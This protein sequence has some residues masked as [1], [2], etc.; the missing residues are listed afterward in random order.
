M[1][2]LYLLMIVISII[3]CSPNEQ[4]KTQEPAET[5]IQ[6]T[7]NYGEILL[8]LYNETPL[9]RDNFTKIV[10]EGVLDSVL[11][12]R[13]IEEFM[14]QAGNPA[15]K[16]ENVDSLYLENYNYR[17]PAEITAE[18]FHKKGALA[19]ARTGNPERESSGTQFYI[20]QGKIF[21]DSLLNNAEERINTW[22]SE[23]YIKQD[24]IYKN[25]LD[26]LNIALEND[27]W[28]E[29]MRLNNFFVEKAKSY[30]N[31]EKYSIPEA[32]K[33]V[34]RSVGGT[35]HLDQNYTVFGEVISGLQVV[36]SIASV[37]TNDRD[38]PIENVRII[39]A[40]VIKEKE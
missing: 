19:A 31:F 2:H 17:V 12:H 32:H 3:G 37:V 36:D 33:T 26:S 24:S 4:D 8:K 15:T 38:R 30:D 20:V 6:L 18:L 16:S 27:N 29:F 14:I 25:Q 34:Y 11:F 9:H 39:K 40:K 28:E 23:H 13:V 1:K 21:N 35:P 10:H 22:L 5:K 7:T